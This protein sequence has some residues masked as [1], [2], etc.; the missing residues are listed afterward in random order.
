MQLNTAVQILEHYVKTNEN[1]ALCRSI[2][3]VLSDVKKNNNFNKKCVCENS[4]NIYDTCIPTFCTN[5]NAY[6]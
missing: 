6:I 3:T 4:K 2:Q 5:C 1:S